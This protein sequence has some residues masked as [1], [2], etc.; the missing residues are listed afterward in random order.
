MRLYS[1]P[2]LENIDGVEERVINIQIF[3]LHFIA[4]FYNIDII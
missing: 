3:R 4:K 2:A 1:E